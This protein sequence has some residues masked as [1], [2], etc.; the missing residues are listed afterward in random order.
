MTSIWSIA[1]A[2]PWFGIIYLVGLMYIL[3]QLIQLYYLIGYKA[4]F[5]NPP[6][7]WPM[8]SIWVAARN[9]AENIEIRVGRYGA[10]LQEGVGDERKFANIPE[11]LAPDEL[12]LEKA[13]EL[14]AAPSGEREL[15]L[16]PSTGLQVIA[17]SGRFGPYITEVFP[18]V[19]SEDG[20]KPRK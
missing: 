13:I 3:V 1:Q 20:K 6:S 4:K 10:Y 17:K 19:V 11:G 7:E 18:E 12:T 15:G 16:D 2:H 8:I 9:E 14:L 5:E